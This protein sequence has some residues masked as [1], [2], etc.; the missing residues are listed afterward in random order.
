MKVRIIPCLDVREGR[1]V[2]GVRFGSL[3]DVGEPSELAA[4]YEDEGADEITLLDITATL[5]ARGHALELTRRV[6]ERIRLPL[7][8]GGGV[9]S[10]ED[11]RA[12]LDHGADKVSLNSAAVQRPEIVTELASRFGRQCVVLAIDAEREGRGWR[13][14]TRSGTRAETLDAVEWAR[15]GARRGAG[16]ILL[17]SFDRDGT[18]EGYDC[19]LLRAVRDAVD[20][21]VVA[22]GGADSPAHMVDAVRAGASAVLAA[23]IFHH[24]EWTVKAVKDEL[25]RDGVEVRSC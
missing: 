17:T 3:R 21:P 16:E 4:R 24:G 15:E 13:V 22:S 5:D 11:A 14:R 9:G 18:R 8:V 1:T 20:L 7:T 10:L 2:K 19:D 23:S 12:V 25:R 6:R